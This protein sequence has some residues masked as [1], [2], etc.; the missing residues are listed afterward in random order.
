[1]P[2]AGFKPAISTLKLVRVS[3]IPFLKKVVLLFKRIYCQPLYSNG[4]TYTAVQF[5]QSFPKIILSLRH[6]EQ[7]LLLLVQAAEIQSDYFVKM[8]GTDYPVT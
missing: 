6:L 4:Y 5:F 1:M 3:N 8:S 7:K 2:S